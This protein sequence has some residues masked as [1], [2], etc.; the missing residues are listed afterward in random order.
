MDEKAYQT[1][2]NIEDISPIGFSNDDQY[3]LNQIQRLDMA[4]NNIQQ[5]SIRVNTQETKLINH[6]QMTSDQSHQ[7]IDTDGKDKKSRVSFEP[8]SMGYARNIQTAGEA[9]VGQNSGRQLN[10]YRTERSVK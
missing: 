4:N 6:R 9:S 10:S 8:T 1:M 3:V 5:E 2:R 7:Y